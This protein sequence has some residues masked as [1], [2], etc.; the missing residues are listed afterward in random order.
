MPEKITI[1]TKR[2]PVERRGFDIDHFMK[3]WAQRVKEMKE[4][5]AATGRHPT[6]KEVLDE[7]NKMLRGQC[8]ECNQGHKFEGTPGPVPSLPEPPPTSPTAGPKK[9]E[10]PPSQ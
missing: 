3:T 9:A 7:Y 1:E 6:R 5:A 8:P 10:Q 2:G 4:Q